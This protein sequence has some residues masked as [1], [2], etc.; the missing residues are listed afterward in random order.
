MPRSIWVRRISDK[1]IS[2]S[3]IIISL[4]IKDISTEIRT[5]ITIA[6][7]SLMNFALINIIFWIQVNWEDKGI[8]ISYKGIRCVIPWRAS[9]T[10]EYLILGGLNQGDSRALVIYLCMNLLSCPSM[11]CSFIK[12]GYLNLRA[13]VLQKFA[14]YLALVNALQNNWVLEVVFVPI[15]VLDHLI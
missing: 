5:I 13:E 9:K 10:S 8:A 6:P 1:N 14:N 3:V 15:F 12:S 7:N 2:S 4:N 11:L